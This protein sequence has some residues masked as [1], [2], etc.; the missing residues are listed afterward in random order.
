MKSMKETKQP[1]FLAFDEPR[2]VRLGENDV[3][4]LCLDFWD[5]FPFFAFSQCDRGLLWIQFR[6]FVNL[7]AVTGAGREPMD[8]LI[9][10]ASLSRECLDAFAE[11]A[12][13]VSTEASL[14]LPVAELM[15]PVLEQ[16]LLSPFYTEDEKH[17]LAAELHR[18][19]PAE[20]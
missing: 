12:R 5:D 9:R 3:R 16:Q 1:S 2:T 10:K 7:V 6:N 15:T 19:P 18:L 4:A 8:V 20:V 11:M 17:G 13:C 14:P